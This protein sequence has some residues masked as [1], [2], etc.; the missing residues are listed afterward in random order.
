MD[1]VSSLSKWPTDVSS[2]LKYVD[3]HVDDIPRMDACIETNKANCLHYHLSS[4]ISHLSNESWEVDW[5]RR[6]IENGNNPSVEPIDWPNIGTPPINEYNTKECLDMAF[7]T[8]FPT[9][10]VDWFHPRICN[11]EMHE[12][13]LHL[14]IFYDKRFG[15]HPC[16]WYLF[17]NMIMWHCSQ[18][19]T[20]YSWKYSWKC[21]RNYSGVA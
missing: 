20:S 10:D 3:S 8:L 21:S 18:G 9:D 5:I 19:T 1:S 14:S 13:V 4:F 11:I 7:P 17:L 6:F 16:F 15:S 2:R 12:Y